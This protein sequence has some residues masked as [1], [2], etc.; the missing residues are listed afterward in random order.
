M[1]VAIM[2]TMARPSA[3]VVTEP[4][5]KGIIQMKVDVEHIKYLLEERSRINRT[6]LEEL[7]FYENG[8]KI[9]FPEGFLRD[10]RYTGLCNT[11][12][13]AADLYR[14][15]KIQEFMNYGK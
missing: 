14:L 6:P 10:F 7:E 15:D 11:D 2:I 5:K 8:V 12:I 4:A 1:V 13:V 3:A 9:E